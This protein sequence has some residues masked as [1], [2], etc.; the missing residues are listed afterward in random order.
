[1]ERQ[2]KVEW[3]DDKS[4]T[5]YT[6]KCYLQLLDAI[7]GG[8]NQLYYSGQRSGA[9][10]KFKVY[11]VDT[12][13]AF[14]EELEGKIK[15]IYIGYTN[16]WHNSGGGSEYNDSL[17]SMVDKCHI[18]VV[19]VVRTIKQYRRKD[20][21]RVETTS[22]LTNT[23]VIAAHSAADALQMNPFSR[24]CTKISIW[25]SGRVTDGSGVIEMADDDIESTA[26]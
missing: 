8:Y 15:P 25:D 6:S 5:C 16:S 24:C 11:P 2:F 14:D 4:T 1:M 3:F 26:V 10:T 12:E 19:E 21:K 13:D 20:G 23:L 18:Y 17:V 7:A 22:T 9:I